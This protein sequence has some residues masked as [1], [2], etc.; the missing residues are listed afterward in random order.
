MPDLESAKASG[1][2]SHPVTEV[3]PQVRTR[4]A[5]GRSPSFDG[6][7]LSD[8]HRKKLQLRFALLGTDG[9]GRLTAD[10]TAVGNWLSGP[11]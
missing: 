8:L 1:I 5:S 2:G 7:M 4:S 6:A 11:L 3:P 10:P 9:D